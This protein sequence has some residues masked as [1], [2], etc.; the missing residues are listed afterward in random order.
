MIKLSK[1]II[2]LKGFLP[3]KF[4]TYLKKFRNYNGYEGLDK[5]MLKYINYSNGFY[6]ECGANDG[7]NQS[8]TWYF[9]KKLNWSGLLIEPIDSVFKELKKNRGKKNFFFKG[10]L[11]QLDFKK[12]NVELNLNISDTLT[13][14]SNLDN[15][16]RVKV[17]V[18]TSNLNFL[19]NKINAPKLIDFFSLDVEGDE[20]L[21][22]KGVNFQKY[23]FRY[24]LIECNNINKLKKFL[25][26]KN[27]KYVEKISNG[28]D[29][30]FKTKKII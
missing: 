6:I 12:K 26:K 18:R 20:F 2:K 4:K 14:R 7:V 9:E 15:V 24:I 10:A 23:T 5:R 29:Y 22:L 25:E 11:R 27:Y 19:L 8:N 17:K 13:T 21:V 3:V 1:I 30:L 28:N 16:K